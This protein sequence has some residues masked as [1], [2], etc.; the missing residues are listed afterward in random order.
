MDPNDDPAPSGDVIDLT[1]LTSPERPSQGTEVVLPA[2]QIS[3]LEKSHADT[4][5]IAMSSDKASLFRPPAFTLDLFKEFI[6]EDD[7]KIIDEEPG[8]KS[9][10]YTV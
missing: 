3:S 2:Q 6:H 8:G 1:S 4:T 7:D 9:T 5:N 10:H